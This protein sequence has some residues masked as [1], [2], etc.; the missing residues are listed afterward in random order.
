MRNVLG[1]H[2][3]GR[4]FETREGGEDIQRHGR[5]LVRCEQ[6]HQ[7]KKEDEYDWKTANHS[8]SG[9]GSPRKFD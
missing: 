8:W 5:Y 3:C 2:F 7:E 1:C 4:N 9:R 6:C